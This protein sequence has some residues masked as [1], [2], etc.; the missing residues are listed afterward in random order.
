M[1]DQAKKKRT[2]A[3]SKFTRNVNKLVTLLEDDA[4][5]ELVSPQY[6]EV[7]ECWKIL[8]DAHDNYLE[9][10]GDED[11]DG[12][13]GLAYLD[14]PGG[15]HSTVLVKY[16]A[17]LK[18]QDEAQ[19]QLATRQAEAD[20][21]LEVERRNREAKEQKDLEDGVRLDELTRQFDSMSL[22]VDSE[23]D[24]FNRSLLNLEGTLSA[25]SGEDRR[26]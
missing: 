7:Q 23:I 21:L 13:G 25:A 14:K 15:D 22:E 20:R 26:V 4:P 24:L 10:I 5:P 18:S 16:S 2:Q 19:R 17:Y 3:L 8:E 11:L 1:A 9:E 6:D 12:P